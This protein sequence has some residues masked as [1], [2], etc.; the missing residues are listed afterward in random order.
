VKRW[1][2]GDQVMFAAVVPAALIAMA[3][4]I[5]FSYVRISAL[6]RELQE[7]GAAIARQLAPASAYGMFSGNQGFLRQLADNAV[8]DSGVDGAAIFDRSGAVIAQSGRLNEHLL[9]D[10]RPSEKLEMRESPPEGLAFVVPVGRL[11]DAAQDLGGRDGDAAGSSRIGSVVV[12]MSLEPLALR[13]TELILAATA[14]TL[15]GLGVAIWLARRLGNDVARPVLELSRTV[16]TIKGGNLGVRSDVEAGGV[17][18]ILEAGINDMAASL[19]EGQRDLEKRVVAAT[20]ELHRQKDLAEQA[21]R[22]KTQFLAAASHDLRQPIQAAG[23]FVSALRL[24][25]KDEDT[26][27]LVSRIERAHAGLEAVLDGLLDISRLDSG[28]VT[29]RVELFPAER[30]LGSLRDSFAATAAE[31]GLTLRVAPCSAWCLSDP[32]LLERVLSNLVSNALRYTTRGGVVVGCRRAGS[33]LRF[34]VWDSGSGIPDE[35]RAEIFREFVQLGNSQSS[36]DKGLG[37]GLAIVERLS[38]LLDHPID[39]RSV[40]GKG[41]VFSVLVKRGQAPRQVEREASAPVG[42]VSSFGGLCILVVDDDPDVLE[43]LVAFLSQVGARVLTASSAAQARQ[44]MAHA[45]RIDALLSDYRLPDSDGVSL[46][47]E[48]QAS[49][50]SQIPGIIISGETAEEV[51]QRV[52]DSGLRLLQKPVPAETLHHALQ[53]LLGVGPG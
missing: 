28:A 22:T 47:R 17:L 41:T 12:F 39:L 29:P 48:L 13:K 49:G 51:L 42:G 26:Q 18:K 34:E 33:S 31:S 23:L 46:V 2:I 37:L 38:R 36:R 40:V 50:R 45:D 1:D 25:S 53:E 19:E 3:M 5:F 8:R 9:R 4:A 21:N 14:I 15:V 24:R 32:L 30:L 35:K 16:S 11:P 44:V 20:A 43:A 27:R 6:E 52:S 10:P 7:H